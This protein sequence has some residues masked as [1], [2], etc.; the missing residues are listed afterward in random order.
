MNN[1]YLASDHAGVEMK[2]TLK[3][4]LERNKYAVYDLGTKNDTSVDYPDYAK[5]IAKAVQNDT[6]SKG[7]LICGTGIGMCMTANK[8]KGIRAA[9]CYNV[10]TAKLSREHN[11]ANILCLG[12]RT[13]TIDMAKKITVAWI[14]TKHE[15]GERHA[16]RIKKIG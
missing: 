13:T 2:K 1:I 3:E 16:R 9:L 10:L 11:D 14:K 4:L 8:I 7:I 15:G 5:K 6:K 12:A